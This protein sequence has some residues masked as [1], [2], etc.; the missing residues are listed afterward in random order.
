MYISPHAFLLMN[1]QNPGQNRLMMDCMQKLTE[2]GNR[3]IHLSLGTTQKIT[4]DTETRTPLHNSL[5]NAKMRCLGF[6][7]DPHDSWSNISRAEWGKESPPN[8]LITSCELW[9]R[10]HQ[11]VLNAE[12]IQAISPS[13][14]GCA[15]FRVCF[16]V[17][18]WQTVHDCSII[19]LVGGSAGP[20]GEGWTLLWTSWSQVGRV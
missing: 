9:G 17:K 15:N 18:A 1:S 14:D 20:P 6:S 4:K 19:L 3:L 7:E 5:I 2:N 11:S 12:L 16:V 10:K 8:I 13:L